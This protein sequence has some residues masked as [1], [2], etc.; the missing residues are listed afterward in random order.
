M[1]TLG[2]IF[3]LTTFGE[4]HGPAIGGVMDG[5]PAG[6]PIDLEFVQQQLDRRRPGQSA[7]TTARRESDRVEILSGVFEGV[8]T[9]TPIGFLVR[10]S[11]QHS[12]DYD[13]LRNV[14]RPSHADYT[15]QMKYG[16]RDHRGGGRSSARET[17]SRVVAGAF[18]M[19]ALRHVGVQIT[20]YTSQV[21]PLVL[22]GDYQQYDFSEIERNPV[23][24]PDP[25]MADKMANLIRQVKAEV[26]NIEVNERRDVTEEDV[27][28]MIKRL[29]KQT[30]ETLEM[31]I[32]AGT[33]QDRTD[34]LTEQV[35]ILESLLPAQVSGE[36]L[37]ALIEQVIAELGATSKK[38]MGQVMGALGKATGGNF[39][40]P[41]AAKIVG[42]KLA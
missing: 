28:S 23:R 19:L 26:K 39:D 37:E 25:K 24:C 32:K 31:S 33:D 42:G 34:N 11:D 15:Y 9:G 18:A 41:A 6:I 27:N 4:S 13:N 29:I 10:N 38:Q 16:V 3:R 12:A 17:V 2:Q 40:K 5:F 7:L 21:G 14:F 36:E 1:N 35:K 30:S 8:S 22:G 20:A